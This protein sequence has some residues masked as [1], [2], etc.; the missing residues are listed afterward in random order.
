[1]P[2]GASNPPLPAQLVRRPLLR[3]VSELR[4]SANRKRAEVRS[5]GGLPVLGAGVSPT[6]TGT[7]LLTGGSR[8][9]RSPFRRHQGLFYVSF[10]PSAV[11]VLDASYEAVNIVAAG[12]AMVL[13]CKGAAVVPGSRRGAY[14]H[15]WPAP[16]LPS[17]D[18]ALAYRY[19]PRHSRSVSRRERHQSGTGIGASCCR[20]QLPASKLR[21]ITSCRD[22]RGGRSSSENLRCL[23]LSCRPTQRATGRQAEAGIALIRKPLPFS[24]HANTVRG[25]RSAV[26][27][28]SFR[29]T[30]QLRGNSLAHLERG[31]A[32]VKAGIPARSRATLLKARPGKTY[33]GQKIDPRVVQKTPGDRP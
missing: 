22:L 24:I 20:A 3:V 7:P 11:F 14:P 10:A 12:R 30:V 29:A 21:S 19:V 15:A 6:L 1:M 16:P 25:E 23:L 32:M 31:L 4:L 9:V 5:S 33:A 8:E 17:V 2:H 27:S 26:G 28:V 18:P 13:L